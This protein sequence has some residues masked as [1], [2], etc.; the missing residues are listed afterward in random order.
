M[1]AHSI[2]VAAVGDLHCTKTSQ[3][4]FQA[5]FARM[6][7]SADVI[8]LCGDLTDHGLPDEARVL[9]KELQ[10]AKVPKVAVLGNHD[11]ESGVAEE[12]AS[13]LQEADV[14]VLDG[15][16]CEVLGVGFAGA[17][18]FAGGFGD[19]AL[20]PWGEGPVKDFVRAA[21]D[22]TL[23]L[24]SALARLRTPGRVVLLHYSPVRGTVDGEPPEIFAFLGSSRLEEPLNR[25]AATVVFHGHAHRGQP[26][27]VTSNG[28]PVYNVALPLLQSRFPDR[29]PFRVVEV[30]V[31][32]RNE[33]IPA[34][35]GRRS[36]H[37]S[38]GQVA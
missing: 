19:R 32:A 14:A 17:K 13:I 25:Y 20:Q 24:E 30:P 37:E 22:E 27:A 29:P 9:A 8:G 18:G 28:T 12:V 36:S 1:T 2:R 15:A 23:K 16:A 11:F 21:V 3:G 6:G 31:E 7:E 26:E 10:A 34:M 5:L 38:D 35:A 4:A 33:E